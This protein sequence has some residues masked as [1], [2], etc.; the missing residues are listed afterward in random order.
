VDSIVQQIKEKNIAEYNELMKQRQQLSSLRKSI[1]A[2]LEL[3]AGQR[4]ISCSSDTQ[5][6]M[7]F[8]RWVDKQIQNRSSQK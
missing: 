8:S 5:L 4:E 7:L 6:D 3:L 2:L 1:K